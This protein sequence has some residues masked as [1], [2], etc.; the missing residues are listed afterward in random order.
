VVINRIRAVVTSDIAMVQRL[1]IRWDAMPNVTE[2]TRPDM[3]TRSRLGVIAVLLGFAA[4][5]HDAVV[6]QQTGPKNPPLI[7]KSVAGRDLFEF[8]CAA[9]HGR[10]GKG[11][12]PVAAALRVPPPDLTMLAARNDGLFP[13]ARVEALVTGDGE[14]PP[15]HGSREMPVW[16]PI[17]RAL[18]ANDRLNR[19]RIANIAEY[20]ASIQVK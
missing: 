2:S 8:Y 18:D 6:A 5:P 3:S 19:V 10:D 13:N 11:R 16:G 17:F 14:V 7:L 20:L 1:Q 15:A 9:C 12:G 4:L